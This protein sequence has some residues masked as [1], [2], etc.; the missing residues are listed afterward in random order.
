LDSVDNSY[1]N[2]CSGE[3][4]FSKIFIVRGLLHSLYGFALVNAFRVI[5]LYFIN[6]EPPADII[7]LYDPLLEK[8]FY[9]DVLITKDL[10]FSGHTSNIV[11]FG[12]LTQVP[13]MRYVI[14]AATFAVGTMLVLQH[15]HYTIDVVAAPFFAYLAYVITD[16]VLG[17]FGRQSAV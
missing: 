17:N 9:Q 11:I 12:F 8:T 10:F 3:S 15:V 4:I 14:F 16:K 2:L 6:L 13:R 1:Y 7:P 5:V